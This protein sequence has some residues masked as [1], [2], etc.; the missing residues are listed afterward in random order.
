MRT[1]NPQETESFIFGSGFDTYSWWHEIRALTHNPAND[2]PNNWAWKVAYEDPTTGESRTV[3]VGH[4]MIMRSVRKIMTR[5]VPTYDSL[6]KESRNLLFNPDN[7]DL[8][9]NDAD[10]IMQVA[11]FGEIVYG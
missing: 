6:V 7:A 3:T 4:P 1:A 2:A 5:Q 9:A 11:L 8:D 10:V